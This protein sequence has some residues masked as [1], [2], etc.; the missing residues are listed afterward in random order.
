M[1]KES[2]NFNK[3]FIKNAN[4]DSDDD[5]QILAG[6][7]PPNLEDLLERQQEAERVY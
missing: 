1:K 6:K 3:N 2:T 4:G 5:V 7:R